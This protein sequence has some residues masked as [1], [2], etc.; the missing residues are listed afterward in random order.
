MHPI[1][2][3]YS[4]TRLSTKAQIKGDGERRQVEKTRAYCGKQG[5]ILDEE[6]KDLGI[7]AFEGKNW[8]RGCAGRFHQADRGRGYRPG[9]RLI[10]EALTAC[11]VTRYRLAAE[12][13][14]SVNNRGVAVVTLDDNERLY[15]AEALDREPLALF[16]S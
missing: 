8:E 15:D 2:K 14:L 7:S 6:L 3:G 4:Y 10:V 1:V 9:S 11:R 12:R 16:G 5:L 13:F